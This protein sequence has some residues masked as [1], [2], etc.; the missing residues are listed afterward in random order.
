[1]KIWGLFNTTFQCIITL[2][3]KTP[4]S[5]AI[6]EKLNFW[7][8]MRQIVRINGTLAPTVD[9]KKPNASFRPPFQSV[10]P[11]KS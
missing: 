10:Y 4:T 3:V 1:M 6:S 7:Q 2:V 9:F 5:P 8:K 11:S